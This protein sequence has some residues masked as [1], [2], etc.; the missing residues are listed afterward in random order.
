MN[1]PKRRCD[2]FHRSP[3]LIGHFQLLNST[4]KLVTIYWENVPNKNAHFS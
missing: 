2:R 1:E 4:L 3:N